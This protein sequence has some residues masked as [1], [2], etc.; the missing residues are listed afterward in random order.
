[1]PRP[2]L[3]DEERS[4]VTTFVMGSVGVEGSSVPAS[5]FYN[6]T[7]RRKAIQDG[8]WVIKKYNCMGCHVI[9]PGQRSVLMDLPMYQSPEGREQLPPYL[10]TEGA[11]VDPN[12]LL[13]FLQDPSLSGPKTG[14]MAAAINQLGAGAKP[15]LS[16]RNGAPPAGAN[17]TPADAAADPA[18]RPQPGANRNGVR[19]YLKARMPTFSFSPNEL[20]I[21]VRFFQAVSSQPEPYVE[22]KLEPLTDEER[23]LARRLFTSPTAPCMKCHVSGNPEHDKNATAPNFL[24]AGGRLKRDWTYRWLLNPQ[25]IAPGTSMPS[26]LFKKEGDRWVVQGTPPEGFEQYHRD[27]ADLL[28]R[29]MLQMTPD[30]QRRLAASTPSPGSSPPSPPTSARGTPAAGGQKVSRHAGGGRRVFEKRARA[31][32]PDSVAAMARRDLRAGAR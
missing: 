22:E 10:T 7:D 9:Q 5:L 28:V 27:H 23:L 11:R 15:M 26:D 29:Y 6:A 4:A 3:T 13:R 16:P 24:M 32:A 21:L 14:E 17:T 1:M 8:W 18:F 19:P 12:W 2:Y 25:A 30:E 31:R 20:R